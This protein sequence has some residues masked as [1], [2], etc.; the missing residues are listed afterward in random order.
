MRGEGAPN[1]SPRELPSDRPPGRRRRRFRLLGQMRVDQ[2]APR[3]RAGAEARGE[4]VEKL[5]QD[6]SA[7]GLVRPLELGFGRRERLGLK[8]SEAHEIDAE[9]SVDGVLVR[10]REPLADEPDDGAR[11]VKRAG[12]AEK[13]APHRAIDAKEAELDPP[14]ALRLPLQKHDEIVGEL[15]ELKFDRFEALDGRSEPPLGAEIGWWKARRDRARSSPLSASSRA[16]GRAPNRAVIGARGLS[17]MSPMRLRP[18][19]A[20][21]ATVFSSRPSAASGRS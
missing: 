8:A 15:A 10:A 18:A 14:R 9:A 17:A 1:R 16:I 12:S 5:G 4:P 11:F 21:S 20:M 3:H 7:L 13:D 6:Q 2:R 19:R